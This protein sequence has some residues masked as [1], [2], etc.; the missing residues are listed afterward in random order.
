MI[1]DNKD[2]PMMTLKEA[3][4][5]D[6]KYFTITR[7]GGCKYCGSKRR[8]WT[9]KSSYAVFCY[10]CAPEGDLLLKCQINMAEK[11]KDKRIKKR[12]KADW[13]IPVVVSDRNK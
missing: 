9:T 12:K 8:Y 4:D 5:K 6:E 10:D 11:E 13:I 2:F 3:F 1:E 7:G